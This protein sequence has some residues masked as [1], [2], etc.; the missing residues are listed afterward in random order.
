MKVL[1]NAGVFLGTDAMSNC[2]YQPRLK[3]C[4]KFL[5]HICVFMSESSSMGKLIPVKFF[6]YSPRKMKSYVMNRLAVLHKYPPEKKNG[7]RYEPETL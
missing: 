1:H 3:K 6:V 5:L 4:F 7:K 2:S